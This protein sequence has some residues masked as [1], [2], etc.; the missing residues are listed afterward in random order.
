MVNT[1]SP[2]YKEGYDKG[3][4][5]NYGMTAKWWHGVG[6]FMYHAYINI[7]QFL[8]LYLIHIVNI[9]KYLCSYCIHTINILVQRLHESSSYGLVARTNG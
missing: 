1:D 9:V 8:C 6:S 2:N 3:Y 7:L 5:L 4:Y